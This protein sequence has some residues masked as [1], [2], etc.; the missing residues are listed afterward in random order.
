MDHL[1][2]LIVDD[3]EDNRLVLQAIS[4][5]LK[6]FDIREA[7]DG[8]EAIETVE[9]WRPDIVLMDIMMP[10]MDGLEA[11]RIIKERF[12]ETIIM[13]V[14]AVMDP[15]ME[16]NM[17][18]IGVSAYIRKPIDKE[19][20]RFKL[21]SFAALIEGYEG[22][23]QTLT[24]KEAINPFS[25]DI[26]HFKTTFAI[27]NEEGM[28]DFGI[29]MLSRS[30]NFRESTCA[31]ADTIIE[32]FYELMRQTSRQTKEPLEIVVEESFEE[33]FISL[34]F[35]SPIIFSPHAS[36]LIKEF[37]KECI[38]EK[39][40]IHIRLGLQEGYLAPAKTTVPSVVSQPESPPERF[41]PETATS[42]IPTEP[43]TTISEPLTPKEVRVIDGDEHAILRHSYTEKTTA[44]EYIS[45]IGGGRPR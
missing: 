42:N 31:K 15:Q 45:E 17:A 33:M 27:P 20:I 34:R 19:L 11:S 5:R 18:S 41:V 37:G 28:M 36:A 29:W 8:I 16:K 7:C 21:E 22:H 23:Y 43:E 35:V 40:K 12:P 13:A 9:A 2:L 26:R 44:E 3:I 6:R 38:L 14:T 24:A 4:R 25:P 30:E 39:H 32:L 10:R 1:K